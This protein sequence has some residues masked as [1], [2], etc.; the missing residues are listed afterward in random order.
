MKRLLLV[1][2]TIGLMCCH[3]VPVLADDIWLHT[4][5]LS[6]H[7]T[8]GDY[9]EDHE[10]IGIEYNDWYVGYYPNSNYEDSFFI[11]KN[12]RW[13]EVSDNIH[14]GYRY[15]IITGYAYGVEIGDVE[16]AP[17]FV[18]VVFFDYEPVSFDLNV[19]G[20]IVA[21]ELKWKL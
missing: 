21:I 10:L 9:N 18:P 11:L 3:A 12:K 20:P 17:A 5:M 4:G 13:Y 8:A 6:K 7:F 16:V 19:L 14:L 15:G 2:M 1:L